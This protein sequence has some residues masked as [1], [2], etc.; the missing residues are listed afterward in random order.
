M[1]ETS[2]MSEIKAI[3]SVINFLRVSS[4][5]DRSSVFIWEHT[6][7]SI[8]SL[9]WWDV[10]LIWSAC[11][12]GK[13]APDAFIANVLET[14]DILVMAWEMCDSCASLSRMTLDLSCSNGYLNEFLCMASTSEPLVSML[15]CWA[16]WLDGSLERFGC[17]HPI[18]QSGLLRRRHW[19]TECIRRRRILRR[20]QKNGW[21][22]RSDRVCVEIMDTDRK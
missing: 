17:V 12:M 7:V 1:D 21:W 22:L 11:M 3:C 2:S 18:I 14:P 5:T 8:A 10:M 9:Q 4:W 15:E 19:I 16:L 13:R 20:S 6:I